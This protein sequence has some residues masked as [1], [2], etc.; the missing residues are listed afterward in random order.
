MWYQYNM[1]P[2]PG[3]KMFRAASTMWEAY[4]L[5]HADGKTDRLD[6]EESMYKYCIWTHVGLRKKSFIDIIAGL[7]QRLYW[8]CLKS[9]WYA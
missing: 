1:E 7:E 2:I 8:T 6:H 5:K 4:N 3:W 9:E